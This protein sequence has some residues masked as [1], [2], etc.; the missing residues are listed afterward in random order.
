MLVQLHRI[1]NVELLRRVV[2]VKR[3]TLTGRGSMI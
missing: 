1:E 2:S 3:L